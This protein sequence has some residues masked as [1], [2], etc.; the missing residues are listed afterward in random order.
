MST[1]GWGGARIG[2]GMKPKNGQ[3]AIRPRRVTKLHEAAQQTAEPGAA[4]SVLPPEDLSTEQ[5]AVWQTYAGLA[6]EKRTLTAHTEGTFRMLCELEVRRRKMGQTIDRDGLTYLKVFVDSAGN[7][8]QELKKHPLIAEHRQLSQRV[9][10]LLRQFCL[11]PFG[12][13]MEGTQ[14]KQVQ[15]PWAQ[16]AQK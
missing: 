13:A 7:E 14:R 10:V 6:I 4:V 8:H 9:E 12:K 2:A 16:V 1:T 5:K 15:N 3:R 11:S